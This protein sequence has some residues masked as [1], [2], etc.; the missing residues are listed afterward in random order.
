MGTLT[1]RENLLFS[2]NLRLPGSITPAEKERRVDETIRELGLTEC[3]NSKVQSLKTGPVL[4]MTSGN[5]PC[6]CYQR[7]YMTAPSCFIRSVHEKDCELSPSSLFKLL[8]I[9]NITT[10]GKT[11]FFQCLWRK[12]LKAQ[13]Q[14][15]GNDTL[16]RNTCLTNI[17]EL[18]TT[19][20]SSN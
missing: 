13:L 6:L 20:Y 10:N 16:N 2:A 17:M 12:V 4:S 11:A 9:N 1:V 3:Q 19:R 18:F 14:I 15:L 7:R 5:I 8:S